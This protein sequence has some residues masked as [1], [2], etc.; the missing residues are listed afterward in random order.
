MEIT[1]SGTTPR[2]YKSF[3]II[4]IPE[5]EVGKEYQ[6]VINSKL[7]LGANSSASRRVTVVKKDHEGVTVLM[8]FL[9]S[10]T[11][12]HYAQEV[13]FDYSTYGINWGIRYLV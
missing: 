2:R 3:T 4:S 12:L 13:Y 10:G 6:I 8:E 11:L 7:T 9:D 1:E 5:I